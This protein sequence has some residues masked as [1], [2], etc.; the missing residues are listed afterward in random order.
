[1]VYNYYTG[2]KTFTNTA[3]YKIKKWCKDN[4]VF[5]NLKNFKWKE[6]FQQLITLFNINETIQR[7]YRQRI[8]DYTPILYSMD[9]DFNITIFNFMGAAN[10]SDTSNHIKA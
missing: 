5:I 8:A 1:V 2:D 9:V 3:Y 10:I 4:K 6:Y 7:V